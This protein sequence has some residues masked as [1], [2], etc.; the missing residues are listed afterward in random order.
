MLKP[1]YRLEHHDLAELLARPTA[2]ELQ[3]AKEADHAS[4]LEAFKIGT[5][6]QAAKVAR[7]ESGLAVDRD[8]HE[9][10]ETVHDDL[11]KGQMPALLDVFKLGR[12]LEAA[13]EADPRPTP[14]EPCEL[15]G[16]QWGFE[17]G[18]DCGASHRADCCCPGVPRTPPVQP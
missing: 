9:A 6:I 14:Q 8:L 3:A 2:E 7:L 11:V 5:A 4:T 12:A 13:V 16:R 1:G 10:A 18:C 15:E 17:D